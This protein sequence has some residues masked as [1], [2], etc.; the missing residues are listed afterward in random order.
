[1]VG[2]SCAPTRRPLPRPRTSLSASPSS[3]SR[4]LSDRF[5]GPHVGSIFGATQVASA[6]G[7]ALGAWPA[8]RIFD[9]TGSYAIAF[10]LAATTAG[11]AARS[12]W[13]GRLCGPVRR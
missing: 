10:T 12:V 1:M 4:S 7:S 9:A 11:V 6:L 5:R 2:R 3:P 13:A 8:G